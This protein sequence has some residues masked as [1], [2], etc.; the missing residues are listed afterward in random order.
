LIKNCIEGTVGEISPTGDLVTDI[1]AS[2]VAEAPNIREVKIQIGPHET[3][4]VHARDHKEPEGTLIAVENQDGFVEVGITG[5]NISE[6]L[7]I[8]FGEKVTIK[9]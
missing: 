2:G 8:K 1:S 9:W 7:G 4:G 6:M 5:M 3:I